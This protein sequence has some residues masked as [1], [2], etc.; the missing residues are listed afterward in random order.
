MG[1]GI[2]YVLDALGRSMQS[3]EAQVVAQAEQIAALQAQ[4]GGDQ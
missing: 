1:D 4:A 3:L 2:L